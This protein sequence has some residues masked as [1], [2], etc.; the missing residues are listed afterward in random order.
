MIPTFASLAKNLTNRSGHDSGLLTNIYDG[1]IYKQ[2]QHNVYAS[3]LTF[4]VN[5]DGVKLFKSP[6][7]SMWP[8]YLRINELPSR[9]KY[10]C[11][12]VL[13]WTMPLTVTAIET[14]K[15]TCYCLAYGT[16]M[17]NLPCI[18]FKDRLLTNWTHCT[19]KVRL[20][21]RKSQIIIVNVY[22]C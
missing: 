8:I 12:K 10:A 18:G 11:N 22:Y 14:W 2:L 16:A 9:I 21:V 13:S 6:Q 7:K 4:G 5:I 1:S 15:S 20:A 19:F 17:P 3:N